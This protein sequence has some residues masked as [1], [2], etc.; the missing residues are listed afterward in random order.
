MS[1][2]IPRAPLEV[3]YPFHQKV[4]LF[5][6]VGP[7]L[8]QQVGKRSALCFLGAFPD[9]ETALKHKDELEKK[10]RQF[11][12]YM[13]DMY[14]FF[15]ILN[16]VHEVGDVKYSHKE[17]NELLE[18]HERTKTQTQQWNE[19]MEHAQLNKIDGWAPVGN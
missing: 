12:I 7:G 2:D 9:K 6:M 3:T 18:V 15:P 17:L 10:S 11:D 1:N 5:Y 16:E 8:R 4:A 13:V 19:R 14:E